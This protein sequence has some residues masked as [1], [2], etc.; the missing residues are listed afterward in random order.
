M[1]LLG[2]RLNEATK[3]Q[4]AVYLQEENAIESI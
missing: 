1:A 4:L 2:A 3:A